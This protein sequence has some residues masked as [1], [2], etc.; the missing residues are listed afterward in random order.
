MP[1]ASRVQARCTFASL[2]LLLLLHAPLARA[3]NKIAVENARVGNPAS[4]WDVTGAGDSTIQGFAT[5]ISAAPGDTVQFKVDTVGSSFRIELY[6]LG[7][8]AGLGARQVATIPSAS[9]LAQSQPSCLDD[10]ATR[11]I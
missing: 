3:Q 5:D 2:F 9:T 11:L 7:W 1:L 10:A 6:R 8:Y 4:E